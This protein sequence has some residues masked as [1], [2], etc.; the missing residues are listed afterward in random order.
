M[1]Q[2]TLEGLKKQLA[3]FQ[4]FYRWRRISEIHEDYGPCNVIN[5]I[6][7]PGLVEVHSS[8]ETD[9]DESEWTHFTKITP[10]K[11]EDADRMKIE[12]EALRA[13]NSD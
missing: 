1:Q 12:A 8:N 9:F 11:T 6:N 13:E 4:K 7:D 10:L 2:Q 5:L 3:D